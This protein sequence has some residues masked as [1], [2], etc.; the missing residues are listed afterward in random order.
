MASPPRDTFCL[1]LVPFGKLHVTRWRRSGCSRS[2]EVSLPNEPSP[3]R[4]KLR[5]VYQPIP[6]YRRCSGAL[7]PSRSGGRYDPGTQ[8]RRRPPRPG[9]PTLR[10]EREESRLHC[11]PP[12]GSSA[13]I[14][15]ATPGR[16]YVAHL[17]KPSHLHP[18][19]NQTLQDT[20]R[21]LLHLKRVISHWAHVM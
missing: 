15:T 16:P 6:S 8:T 17:I 4:G 19:V 7:K 12:C 9:P 10:A 18:G 20:S 21:P 1:Y 14:P 13:A 2:A 5:W 3:F 11:G